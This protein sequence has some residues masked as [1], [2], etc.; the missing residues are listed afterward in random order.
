MVRNGLERHQQGMIGFIPSIKMGAMIGYRSRI[1]SD[2]VVLLDFDPKIRSIESS[3]TTIPYQD[4]QHMHT[5]RADFRIVHQDGL[6][7]RLTLC[8]SS[9]QTSHLSI[10]LIDAS[11]LWCATHGYILQFVTDNDIY[12]SPRL[13]NIKLLRRFADYDASPDLIATILGI[14]TEVG[15]AVS[16]AQLAGATGAPFREAMSAIYYLTYHHTLTVPIDTEDLCGDSPITLQHQDDL[17]G[18]Y[19]PVSL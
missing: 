10:R 15:P 12:S 3:S 2:Y 14:I 6:T 7:P 17:E 11:Q 1:G 9:H 8:V 18:S 16:I 4:H 5:C 13:N 19:A